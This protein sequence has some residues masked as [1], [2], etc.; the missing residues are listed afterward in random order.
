MNEHLAVI[1]R[2]V[3]AG[4]I[5][6]LILDGAGWHSSPRLTVPENLVLLQCCHPTPQNLTQ[7]RT[8]GLT[9]GAIISVTAPTRIM[10]LSS[11]LV[12]MRGTP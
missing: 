2:G 5:V 6:A 8:F 3:A 1:S 12:A 10:K 9:S 4:A 7:L 11:M